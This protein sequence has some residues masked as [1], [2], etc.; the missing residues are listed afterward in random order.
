M[1][2]KKKIFL[3]FWL[4]AIMPAHCFLLFWSRD[5]RPGVVKRREEQPRK[6]SL[7]ALSIM[8]YGAWVLATSLIS[9]WKGARVEGWDCIHRSGA[10]IMRAWLAPAWGKRRDWVERY[11]TGA[12]VECEY[13]Y[14]FLSFYPSSGFLDSFFISDFPLS[15]FNFLL[16]LWSI[17]F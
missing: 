3:C 10:S 8:F 6:S 11:L 17:I 5:S 12:L 13:T 16:M 4:G 7:L 9:A 14:F 2:K 15:L 1:K